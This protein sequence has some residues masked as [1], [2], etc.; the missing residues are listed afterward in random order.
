MSTNLRAVLSAAKNN[1]SRVRPGVFEVRA[2]P[3]WPTSALIR[4][5]LPT[6]DRPA[7]AIS[8]PRAAG[9]EDGESAAEMKR[10]SRANSA[11]PASISAD[12]NIDA[13]DTSIRL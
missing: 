6:L 5:D 8:T 3:L 4:L 13:L 1:S 7:K 9:S 10:H 2:S 12:E 11:R